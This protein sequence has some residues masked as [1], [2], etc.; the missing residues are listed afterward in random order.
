MKRMQI[1]AL[2]EMT[3]SGSDTERREALLKLAGTLR[4]RPRSTLSADELAAVRAWEA[5]YRQKRR[6]AIGGRLREEHRDYCREQI[7]CS[8]GYRQKRKEYQK[9]HRQAARDNLARWRG[10]NRD[11]VELYVARQRAKRHGEKMPSLGEGFATR[12]SRKQ[13]VQAAAGAVD[14]L[15]AFLADG[16][17]R[18]D[19]C[20]AHIGITDGEAW[21]AFLEKAT[22]A[23]PML[24]EDDDGSLGFG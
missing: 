20:M 12:S 4:N 2:W 13:E 9:A 23:L 17:K 19:E 18:R 10:E 21:D 22:A 8:E 24:W 15:A 6:E 1:A 11:R 7:A 16:M 5:S 3:K 14:A